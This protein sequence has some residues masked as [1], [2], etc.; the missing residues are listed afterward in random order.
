VPDALLL[1]GSAWAQG[2]IAEISSGDTAWLLTSAALVM[3]M[4]AP[5]LA[6]FYGGLVSQRNVLSTLMQQLLLAVPNQR[7][8][9]R[10]RV[11]FCRSRPAASWAVCTTF[12]LEVWPDSRGCRADGSAPGLCRLSGDVCRDHDP[13]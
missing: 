12:S 6:L 13:R 5:G 7:A 10:V 8:V 11:Q 9:G 2:A 3:M 4:T 1:A